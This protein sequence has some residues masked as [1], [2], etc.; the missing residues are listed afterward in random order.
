M[1]ALLVCDSKQPSE[2][3]PPSF[4]GLG[5]ASSFF[6]LLS[7]DEP[8][9]TGFDG[10]RGQA[11]RAPGRPSRAPSIAIQCPIT[12]SCVPNP[13]SRPWRG[14]GLFA[15]G[16]LG[17]I[18]RNSRLSAVGPPASPRTDEARDP[19]LPRPRRAPEA[20]QIRSTD[21]SRQAGPAAAR[22]QAL[23]G[24]SIS[25]DGRWSEPVEL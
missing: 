18:V 21:S 19:G 16:A 6:A 1:F 14:A 17:L 11:P 5:R 13:R 23:L 24:G 3:L 7:T 25:I 22:A 12:L 20:R 9:F 15:M 10:R 2:P 8:R 4:A